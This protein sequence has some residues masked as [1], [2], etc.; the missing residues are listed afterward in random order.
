MK[1]DSESKNR[2]FER[3]IENGRVTF[4]HNGNLIGVR[5]LAAD[6]LPPEFKHL[7]D[8]NVPATTPN[9]QKKLN[10]K[11]SK[12]KQ[13][14][15]DAG[16][17]V[18][19]SKGKVIFYNFILLDM[20]L[21][22]QYKDTNLIK[23][24]A[25]SVLDRGSNTEEL[26]LRPASG[27]IFQPDINNSTNK[28]A[29]QPYKKRKYFNTFTVCI[30]VREFQKRFMDSI[31][32]HRKINSEVVSPKRTV[33]LNDSLNV[34]TSFANRTLNISEIGEGGIDE[35]ERSPKSIMS[36]N[37]SKNSLIN[38]RLKHNQSLE[39]GLNKN[40]SFVNSNYDS[41]HLRHKL[42]DYDFNR[43]VDVGMTSVINL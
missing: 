11:K 17:S 42:M 7:M 15:S 37:Y 32:K 19:H 14:E 8:H 41:E 16:E 30:E 1:D 9:I 21:I 26:Q 2:N 20:S 28:I 13:E 4:D 24:H 5:G 3:Q 34:S 25:N 6:K 29:G 35:N 10:I 12:P 43:T 18:M 33:K 36:N 31:G 40:Y 27:V 23:K 38:K 22:S 39:P